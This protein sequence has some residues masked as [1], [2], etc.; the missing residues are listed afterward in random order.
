LTI[1]FI[2]L[3]AA[4]I[5]QTAIKLIGTVDAVVA[6]IAKP[7]STNARTV[8]AFELVAFADNCQAKFRAFIW[9]VN[10]IGLSV[11]NPIGVDEAAA[12]ASK[13]C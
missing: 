2:D 8:I 4:F 12:G 7:S 9:T 6:T 10:T 3:L 5:R 13:V 1:V 11:A